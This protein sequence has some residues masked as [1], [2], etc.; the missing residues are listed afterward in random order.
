MQVAGAKFS[1]TSHP[2]TTRKQRSVV[3]MSHQRILPALFIGFV[4]TAI[5]AQSASGYFTGSEVEI[6]DGA[7]S[8]SG[9]SADY[10]YRNY[11]T[12]KQILYSTEGAYPNIAKVYD[13][14]D[15]WE[16]TQDLADR[17]II[18]IKIS[19]NVETDEDE[20]EILVMA[21]HHAREWPT[22]EI[23]TQLIENLTM[24]YGSDPRISWLVDNREIWI[25]PVVNPDGLDFSLSDP[26]NEDWRKNRR[27]NGDGTYGVD[28]NRN[29]NGSQ[30]GDPLGEWG[31]AGTSNET[32]QST[33][34]GEYP[35][36]EPETQAIRDLTLNHS[37]VVAL[38][39]HTYGDLVMWPWG[40]TANA[41]PDDIDL[42]RIGNEMA[43]LNGYV[44]DQSIGLYPTTGD[45]LDWLYGGADVFSFLFEVGGNPDGFHPYA[46]EVVLGQIAENIPPALLLIE[47]AGDRHDRQF[48]IE[49]Q[50]ATEPLEPGSLWTVAADITAAR[51]V[52]TESLTVE[53]RVE[54][55]PWVE[56][57][58][59]K[60]SGNDTYAA[61]I[62]SPA[63]GSFVEYYISAADS[64]GVSLSS[65]RYAPYDVYSL[66]VEVDETRPI[67]E[68]GM[69]I[70]TQ[71]GTPITFS[72]SG[73]TDNIGVVNFT[74]TFECDSAPVEL[75]GESP[76]YT[77][78]SEG[79]YLVTL[80]VKDGAGNSDTDTLTVTVTV[81]A[82]PEF[83]HA[84]IPIVAILALFVLFRFKTLSGRD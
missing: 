17:D 62:E 1:S 7:L 28:L 36:S 76:H 82:I 9:P 27:N 14:G 55:G 12:L 45:S 6:M 52:N 50:P 26:A 2:D 46:E 71:I 68:A 5:S 60:V 39:L 77:F 25:I 64:G 23:A 61:D 49:H 37:F 20:P 59:S 43:A 75:Y 4:L 24:L 44:A 72:G 22:S 80:E 63:S 57:S 8:A 67:A 79:E 16:K 70:V 56:V 10:P 47:V 32:W 31:G 83:G 81:D 54:G 73:S 30:N 48:D 78:W 42:V 34:C 38:D 69:D 53:Y 3:T 74:W 19:D 65:P 21:L 41:T 58:M 13:I 66:F 18:A 51:G 35:F 40:Y 84:A 15:G 33:Y 29:Y 11:T